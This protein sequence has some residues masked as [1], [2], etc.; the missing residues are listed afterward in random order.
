MP[1]KAAAGELS[2]RVPPIVLEGV[3]LAFGRRVVFDGL[4]CTMAAGR[5]TVLLGGSGSGKSTLLRSVG[6]LQP[7]DR[8]RIEVGGDE[9]S[10]RDVAALRRVR[11][12]IGMLF[13]H[14][15]LIDS[16]TIFENVAL[17]LREHKGGEEA[18]IRRAVHENLEAVGL[19]D[20]DELLPGELSGGMQRRAALARAIAMSPEILLCD[21]PFSGLDPP[22]VARIE[23]L[24]TQLNRERGLTLVVTSH[25]VASSL[26][27]ADQLVLLADGRAISGT[28]DE[29][30]S[31]EDPAIVAFLAAEAGLVR[32]GL[33]RR[34]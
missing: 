6:G 26:R 16:M 24:L 7:I 23:A 25:H 22:N 8:G 4:D 15:A 29:L 17:P 18:A 2:E 13:Q 9:V 1:S 21:E 11:R 34:S 30:A 20:I 14:G 19:E 33:W 3:G 31:S 10:Q 5:I 27:M 28:P 32:S 12:R